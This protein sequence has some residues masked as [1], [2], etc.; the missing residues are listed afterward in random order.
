MP[1]GQRSQ[2]LPHAAQRELAHVVSKPQDF[3]S[4]ACD[5]DRHISMTCTGAEAV[6]Y[7]PCEFAP[8]GEGRSPAKEGKAPFYWRNRKSIFARSLAEDLH[9]T[10]P[11]FR[12]CDHCT[13]RHPFRRE[14]QRPGP[15]RSSVGGGAAAVLR[16][17]R[18][19]RA[20]GGGQRLRRQGGA[21]PQSAARRSDVPPFLRRAR[22]AAGT[23]A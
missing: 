17:D 6:W 15:P 21:E 12:R 11:A 5:D 2:S 9:V 16:A 13:F 14:R 18:A 1:L 10:I 20:T 3:R 22:A 7:H 23:D 19:A 4:S 8:G